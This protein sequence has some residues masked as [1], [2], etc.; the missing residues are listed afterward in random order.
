MNSK[1]LFLSFFQIDPMHDS[2]HVFVEKWFWLEHKE[3]RSFTH[4]L[5]LFSFMAKRNWIESFEIHFALQL[6]L[7]AQ[8]CIMPFFLKKKYLI[9][10]NNLIS[11]EEGWKLRS[12]R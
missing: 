8:M 3:H 12:E 1:T 10:I 5:A 7:E 2:S 9:F 4:S 6:C 11:F